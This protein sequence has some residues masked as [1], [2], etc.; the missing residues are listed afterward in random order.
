INCKG[1]L[2]ISGGNI[3]AHS[4]GNDA[5]DSN[6]NLYINGGVVIAEGAGGAECGIDAAEGYKAYINGG[7]VV[8]IGGNIQ[9][10][11]SSSKQ[12]SVV[13]TVPANY[14]IGLIDG[15]KAILGYTTPTGNATAMMIS[16]PELTSGNTYTLRGACTLTGG[17][18]FYSLASGCQIGS[19][20]A[21][22]DVTASIAI[23]GTM[24]GGMGGP[25]GRRY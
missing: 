22:V 16:S 6:K 18:T 7:T 11:D 1:D 14:Q 8:A 21:S 13:C 19:G 24:G 2:T 25:G 12:A 17:T 3:Y 4:T 23:S 9:A 20:S 5:I 10:I 15:T